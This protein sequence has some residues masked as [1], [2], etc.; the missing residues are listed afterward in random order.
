MSRFFDNAERPEQEEELGIDVAE[1]ARPDIGA[2]ELGGGSQ[3]VG[4]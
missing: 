2:S 3:V 4:W 1:I